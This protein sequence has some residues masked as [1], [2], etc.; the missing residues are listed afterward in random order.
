MGHGLLAFLL[1][2]LRM[3]GILRVRMGREMVGER[4]SGGER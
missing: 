4:D 1:F 3:E 2:L